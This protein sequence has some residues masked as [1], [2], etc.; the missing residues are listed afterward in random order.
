M[1]GLFVFE[2]ADVAAREKEAPLEPLATGAIEAQ[3]LAIKNVVA[4][5]HGE[6]HAGDGCDQSGGYF[7]ASNGFI[8][9]HDQKRNPTLPQT[10]R[11]RRAGEALADDEDAVCHDAHAGRVCPF[12]P[13][14]R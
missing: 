9:I 10:P 13:R 14:P 6:A 2:Q 8:T 4:P 7:G 12:L 11:Q 3:G 5:A 1:S